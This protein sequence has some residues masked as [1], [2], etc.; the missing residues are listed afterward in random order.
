MLPKFCVSVLLIGELFY[1]STAYVEG[2]ER[3]ENLPIPSSL[4]P[5]EYTLSF[6][7]ELADQK[8]FFMGTAII[9][10]SIRLRHR[11]GE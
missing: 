5:L 8:D 3:E 4:K 9:K 11:K 7:V 10:V 2:P 1:Y 6:E